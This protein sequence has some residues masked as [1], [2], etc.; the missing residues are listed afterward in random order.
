MTKFST[1][2]V[3]ALMG[4]HIATSQAPIIVP[5]IAKAP[6]LEDT[7]A[8]LKFVNEFYAWYVAAGKN[9]D[10]LRIALKKKTA[11]FSKELVLRLNEDYQAAAKSPDEIVGLDFDPVLNSQDFA[12]KYVATKVTKKGSRFLVE[13]FATYGGKRESKPAVI[14][15]LQHVGSRWVFT[16]F[17]YKDGPKTDDLLSILKKLKAERKGR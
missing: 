7:K 9:T 4:L 6:G 11:N 16:N 12:D 15:E 5:S 17:L 10:P 13:V 2:L 1:T 3:F 14:P 8:C